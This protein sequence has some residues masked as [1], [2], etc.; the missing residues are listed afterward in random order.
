MNFFGKCLK[1]DQ[2]VIFYG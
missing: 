2:N 1:F